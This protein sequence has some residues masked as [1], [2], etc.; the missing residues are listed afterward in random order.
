[1]QRPKDPS[2]NKANRPQHKMTINGTKIAKEHQITFF[3]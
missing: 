3:P 2:E 1:M